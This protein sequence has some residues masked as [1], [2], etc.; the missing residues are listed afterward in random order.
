LLNLNFII[1]N[2][3]NIKHILPIYYFKSKNK[4]AMQ[5]AMQ[6][7]KAAAAIRSNSGAAT[8]NKIQDHPISQKLNTFKVSNIKLVIVATV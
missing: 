7:A 1:L 3:I 4:Q 2:S 5:I 6:I 8:G